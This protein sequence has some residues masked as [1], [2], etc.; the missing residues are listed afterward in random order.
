MSQ[1]HTTDE[2]A[3]WLVELIRAVPV[4]VSMPHIVGI[5][6]GGGIPAVS[7][8]PSDAPGC[9]VVAGMH[10][11]ELTGVW[12]AVE[13]AARMSKKFEVACHVVPAV[14]VD[15]VREHSRR[16]ARDSSLSALLRLKNHR[17]LEGQFR[18]GAHPE[19]EDLR[20]WLERLPRVDAFISLHAAN[21]VAP[22]GFVYLGGDDEQMVAQTAHAVARRMDEMS[23]P[24][25]SADPT[26]VGGARIADGVFGLPQA[27]GSC[28]DFVRTALS[29][30]VVA[31][32]ELPV[33]LVEVDGAV[34][35][36]QLDRWKRRYTSGDSLPEVC[37][38]DCVERHIDVLTRFVADICRTLNRRRS[39]SGDP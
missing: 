9:V 15:G 26:G 7:F 2:S 18:S 34:T 32:T 25:L 27:P 22:G 23:F 16:V 4:D 6:G 33:G 17:D 8:G 5:D 31:V 11:S 21:H 38:T 37:V 24:R 10:S 1:A 19:A 30:A 39:L 12:A 29:P 28:I 35:L 13:V 20:R 14:D 36:A 3:E